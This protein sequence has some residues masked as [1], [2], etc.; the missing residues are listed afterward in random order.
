MKHRRVKLEKQTQTKLSGPVP[1]H[2]TQNWWKEET[3]LT[4][5]DAMGTKS[6]SS[7]LPRPK[8]LQADQPLLLHQKLHLITSHSQKQDAHAALLSSTI[9]SAFLKLFTF[10]LSSHMDKSDGQSTHVI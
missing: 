2:T 3:S 7:L 5:T 6:C 1:K 8:F 10:I 9:G 4:A